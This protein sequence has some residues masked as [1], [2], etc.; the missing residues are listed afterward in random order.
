MIALAASDLDRVNYETVQNQEGKGDV[1]YTD[2]TLIIVP[3][4]CECPT[5][6]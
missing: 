6:D 4:P 1:Y 3:P 5:I 2:A